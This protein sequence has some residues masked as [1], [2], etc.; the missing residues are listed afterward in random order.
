MRAVIADPADRVTD[1]TVHCAHH[2]FESLDY[3]VAVMAGPEVKGLINEFDR[4][5]NGRVILTREVPAMAD[6]AWKQQYG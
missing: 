4:C 1:R 2:R 5:W 6:N 3:L